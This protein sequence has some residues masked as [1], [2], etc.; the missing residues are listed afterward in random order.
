MHRRH[1]MRRWPISSE[2]MTAMIA[3]ALVGA[4]I[5]ALVD[6]PARPSSADDWRR[7]ATGWER[8]SHWRSPAILITSDEPARHVS[9]SG[10]FDTHPAVIALLQLTATLFVLSAYPARKSV[11]S[12][13]RIAFP[14]QIA[15][16]F[17]A[18]AFGS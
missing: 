10:R 13:N 8:A 17:R 3:S 18:S 16:S 11:I 15:R 7:T 1:S 2:I 6:S 14:T 9:N 12:E 5:I 4:C